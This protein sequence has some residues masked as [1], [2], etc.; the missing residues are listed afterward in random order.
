[1]RHLLRIEPPVA[2]ATYHVVELADEMHTSRSAW[3][4]HDECDFC[5]QPP[6]DV[7][8]RTITSELEVSP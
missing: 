8:T 3:T 2:A 7:L 5:P 1:M 4:H 6:E